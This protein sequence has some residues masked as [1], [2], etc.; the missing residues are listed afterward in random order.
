MVYCN[1]SFRRINHL[2]VKNHLYSSSGVQEVVSSTDS[3]H[4]FYW[5]SLFLYHIGYYLL[6]DQQRY[7]VVVFWPRRCLPIRVYRPR[8]LHGIYIEKCHTWRH[9]VYYSCLYISSRN[10]I[11]YIGWYLYICKIILHVWLPIQI[12][13][14]IDPLCSV[15]SSGQGGGFAF[16]S[17]K[18]II[19]KK[20]FYMVNTSA[21]VPAFLRRD[22]VSSL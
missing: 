3:S 2:V 4:D 20:E 14:S 5:S 11:M 9:T 1:Y 6:L 22:W 17:L 19:Y 8:T 21:F 16:C 10:V 13:Y 15:K 18:Y 7:A 12:I